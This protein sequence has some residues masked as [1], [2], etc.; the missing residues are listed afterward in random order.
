MSTWHRLAVAALICVS[1]TKPLRSQNSAD[2]Q[3][4][5]PVSEEPQYALSVDVDLVNITATVIDQSGRSVDG[6]TAA[7][8]RVL[9]DGKEQKIAFFSR[10]SKVPISVGLLIDTSGSLQDKLRQGLQTVREIA[11]TLSSNDETLVM[12]FNSKVD[13]RQKFTTNHEDIQ[14]ALGDIRARGE[15]AVFDAIAAGL[16]EMQSAKHQKWI[17][18]LVSDGFDTKSR[19]KAAEAEELV[20]R[21]D[22]LL[23]VIGIDD[24]DNDPSLR[25]R[26]RYHIYDYMLGKLT[27]AGGGRLIRLYTGHDYDLRSLSHLLLGEFHQ[28]YTM[29]YY[30]RARRDSSEWRD[31]EVQVAKPDARV[32]NEKLHL[33]L[34][35][36]T[37]TDIAPV[38]RRMPIR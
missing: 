18:I 28:E 21:S 14:R 7:D 6:L 12:T 37:V 27:S 26:T 31:I 5:P 25:R 3:S 29:A 10:E 13:V 20:K 38:P 33:Q 19:I 4:R 15:T 34:R 22:V 16:R 36:S 2:V 9:E 17:L 32:L 11:A 30:S 35:G 24:P 23:Y 8:F 1:T